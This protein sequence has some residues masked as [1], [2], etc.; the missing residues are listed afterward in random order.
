MASDAESIWSRL[1]ANR[2]LIIFCRLI[3]AATFFLSSFGKLV[4]IEHYSVAMVF[5][6]GILPDPLAIAFGWALPFI[7]LA[8][9][10]GLLCGVLTRLS[11]IG[12]ASM[13]LSFFIVKAVLLSRGMDIECG[14][15]GAVVST[16]ASWSVYL[17]PIVF[18]L[19]LPVVFAPRSSRHRFSIG[20]RLPEAWQR[21]L[22]AIL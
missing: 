18:I 3:L 15:F 2:P 5:N 21:K 13:N 14:C 19:A 22:N 4:N 6:F 16:M 12:V 1:V 11:A 17:D 10:L 7:E 8:C 20:G 9:A